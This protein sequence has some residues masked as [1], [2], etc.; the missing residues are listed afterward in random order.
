[1]KTVRV[2]GMAIQYVDVDFIVEVPDD[3]MDLEQAVED[4]LENDYN[5]LLDAYDNSI[6]RNGIYDTKL[7]DFICY[8]VKTEKA[9]KERQK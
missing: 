7:P 5:I 6:L 9:L 8:K 2:Q 3:T 4:I 1:M